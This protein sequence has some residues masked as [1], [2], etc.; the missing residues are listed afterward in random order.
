MSVRVRGRDDYPQQSGTFN[1][2]K[3][4][5]GMLTGKLSRYPLE[6]LKD[7]PRAYWRMNDA[8]SSTTIADSSGNGRNLTTVGTVLFQSDS[9]TG[10]AG[11]TM[12][13]T[14][15][16]GGTSPAHL[17]L[18]GTGAF[19]VEAWFRCVSVS[20]SG[21]GVYAQ[22]DPGATSN[23]QGAI[24]L[25][26][27]PNGTIRFSFGD[28]T[29]SV[30]VHLTTAT[31]NDGKWHHAVFTRSSTQIVRVY[32]DNTLLFA[33]AA[34]V[35]FPIANY[36]TSTIG[37]GKRDSSAAFIGTLADIAI[38]DTELSAQRV[39][40]HYNARVAPAARV[41]ALVSAILTDT[42]YAYLRG[43]SGIAGEI[44][45][46]TSGQGVVYPSSITGGQAGGVLGTK[47]LQFAGATPL[48]DF[49]TNVPR[50]LNSWTMEFFC[51]PTQTISVGGTVSPLQERIFM[52]GATIQANPILSPVGNGIS[53]TPS[54]GTNGI[55]IY[56]AYNATVKL[57]Y[58]GTITSLSHVV[59]VV[60]AKNYSLYLNGALVASSATPDT[61]P[62]VYAPVRLTNTPYLPEINNSTSF[63]PYSGTL[64][65]IALYNYALSPT[66][67][68]EHANI[69]LGVPTDETPL[70]S[71]FNDIFGGN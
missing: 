54:V 42:P 34:A 6:V 41:N 18:S 53:V 12:Y 22:R 44:D 5:R 66:R 4:Y 65:H 70:W 27:D 13:G 64:S 63:L 69:G 29:S 21:G 15:N 51:N 30:F 25:S 36:I 56:D 28:E 32:I 68:F 50:G 20:G 59:L 49:A 60:S 31:Y 38:Y 52:G 24:S 48:T 11:A 62:N 58:S 2:E 47:A 1:S 7:A 71:P 57:V 39:Q 61:A 23:V 43:D 33:S 26:F 14:A 16:N 46:G 40:A 8:L 35:T 55:K 67:I 37:Y 45:A 3:H 10:A 19:T 17:G 9:P